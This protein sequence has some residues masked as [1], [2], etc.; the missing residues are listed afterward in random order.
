MVRIPRAF[1]IRTD[2]LDVT[3]RA[4][5]IHEYQF[6]RSTITDMY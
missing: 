1:E 2:L 5:S 6:E 3:V 4:C